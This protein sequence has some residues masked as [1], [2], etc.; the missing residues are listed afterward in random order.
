MASGE[1]SGSIF[2]G[3]PTFLHNDAMNGFTVLPSRSIS[4][5]GELQAIIHVR[6]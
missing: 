4:A 5:A 3:Q 6:N 1:G 2:Q